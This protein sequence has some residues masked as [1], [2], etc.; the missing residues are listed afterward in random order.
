MNARNEYPVIKSGKLMIFHNGSYEG[1]GIHA[2]RASI[3]QIEA[4]PRELKPST[5]ARL[6][7]L[8]EAVELW[9]AR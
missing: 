2:A 1:L 7:L 4:S 8:K 6:A 9:E 5:L 3:R